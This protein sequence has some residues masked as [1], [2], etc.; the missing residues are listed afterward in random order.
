MTPVSP[1]AI[2]YSLRDNSLTHRVRKC[3][4][5]ISIQY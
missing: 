1:F 2:I 5:Y 4:Y 3:I